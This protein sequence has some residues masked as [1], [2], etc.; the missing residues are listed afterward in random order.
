V[1]VYRAFGFKSLDEP[2]TLFSCEKKLWSENTGG[3]TVWDSRWLF[4]NKSSDILG[5][6]YPMFS[7]LFE[8][9]S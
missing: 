4:R 5:K 8:A 2:V 3:T 6:E 9:Q 7:S 1:A